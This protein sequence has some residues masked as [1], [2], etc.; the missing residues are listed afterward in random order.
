MGVY[1]SMGDT[2]KGVCSV[3][4]KTVYGGSTA[5]TVKEAQ[6]SMGIDWLKWGDLKES[7]PPSY[8]NYIG[9]IFLEGV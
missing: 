7:I 9:D 8:T 6:I 4:G 1:G 3:T 5:K 2:V